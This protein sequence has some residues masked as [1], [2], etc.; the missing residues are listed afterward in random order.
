MPR[1]ETH[2]E[3][4]FWKLSVSGWDIHKWMDELWLRYGKSHRDY[5][6]DPWTWIP[7]RFVYTYGLELARLI[8]WTHIE[9]DDSVELF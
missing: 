5:R 6:H 3:Y 4:T 1:N 9:L 7:F 2:K 8:V